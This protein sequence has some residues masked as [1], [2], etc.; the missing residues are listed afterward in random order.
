[1]VDPQ[2]LQ[3][4]ESHAS[5]IRTDPPK[6]TRIPRKEPARMIWNSFPMV[7]VIDP[8][9]KFRREHERWLNRALRSTKP[10][11]KPL[12]RIP[13][14]PVSRGGFERLMSSERG[15]RAVGRWW[16]STLGRTDL[17]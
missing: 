9:E 16:K 13:L 6:R 1:M 4:V 5:G 10:L 11:P 2:I 14:R 15:R 12:P 7:R 3:D 17:S 8:G